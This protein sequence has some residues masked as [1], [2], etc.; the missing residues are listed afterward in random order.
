MAS[1]KNFKKTR[2]DLRKPTF[3]FKARAGLS[4]LDGCNSLCEWGVK[5]KSTTVFK[6][7]S[8]GKPLCPSFVQ[9]VTQQGGI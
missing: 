1:F 4:P 6:L 9:C 3:M 8:V 5:K 2:R 7:V